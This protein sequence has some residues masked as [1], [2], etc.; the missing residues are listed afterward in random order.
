MLQ[1]ETTK[2][3]YYLTTFGFEYYIKPAENIEYSNDYKNAD[4]G[5]T[6]LVDIGVNI[7]DPYNGRII[8]LSFGRINNIKIHQVLDDDECKKCG[9]NFGYAHVCKEC[10]IVEC[11]HCNNGNMNNLCEH[12]TGVSFMYQYRKC[13]D[14]GIYITNRYYHN[15]DNDEDFC[16]ECSVNHDLSNFTFRSVDLMKDHMGSLDD[17][18][19][20]LLYD[21]GEPYSAKIVQNINKDSAYFGVYGILYTTDINVYELV[22]SFIIISHDINEAIAKFGEIKI[23][24]LTK[25][26][27]NR[28]AGLNMF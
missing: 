21:V 2:N 8:P 4:L 7:G 27:S 12:I 1:E 6:G 18:R 13:D 10:R 23:K 20:I 11:V 24:Y 5:E 25:A 26:R 15:N 9:L 22:N 14:C 16:L 28:I 19:S 3:D 17:W